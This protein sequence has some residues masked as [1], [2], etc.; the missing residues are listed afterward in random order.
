MNNQILDKLVE[1]FITKIQK[2]DYQQLKFDVSNNEEIDSYDSFERFSDPSIK[3][4][5]ELW[6]NTQNVNY[7]FLLKLNEKTML[8]SLTI[9]DGTKCQKNQGWYFNVIGT[10]N[11]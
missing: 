11:W 1:E 6:L 9:N 10:T 2:I 7:H 4:D 8:R 5:L 3:N